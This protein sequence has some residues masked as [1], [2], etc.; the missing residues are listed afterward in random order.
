[1]TFERISSA[2]SSTNLSWSDTGVRDV[3]YVAGMGAVGVSGDALGP[4]V[5]RLLTGDPGAFR[6]AKQTIWRKMM[7]KRVLTGA[8]MHDIDMALQWWMR[9]A[10]PDCVNGHRVIPDTVHLREEA[11]ETCKGTGKRAHLI[12]TDTYGKTL[13][14]LDA[15]ASSCGRAVRGKVA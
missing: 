5:A 1:M 2:T 10:C 4:Q 12:G 7:R 9:P 14:Y 3:D 8:D 13:A 6:E 11:C 15:A